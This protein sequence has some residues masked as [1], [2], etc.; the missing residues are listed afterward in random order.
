[1][2]RTAASP[3][4]DADRLE[5]RFGLRVGALLNQRV[6]QTPHDVSERLRIAREQAVARARSARLATAGADVALG[7]APGRAAVL[8]RQPGWW[9]RFASVVP[10]VMLVGGLILIDD[11]HDRAQIEAAADVDAALLSDDLPPDAY[12]DA[13]FVE[14]LKHPG[15]E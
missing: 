11:L 15:Q 3:L 8:G 12:G 9:F 2:N 6:Q 10:L 14:F 7:G 1:M 5:A 13:G 4:T